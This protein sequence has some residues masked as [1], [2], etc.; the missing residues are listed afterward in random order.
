MEI[1]AIFRIGPPDRIL[2]IQCKLLP[3]HRKYNTHL[4]SKFR[5]DLWPE[6]NVRTFEVI[7]NDYLF[8]QKLSKLTESE[9]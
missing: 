6:K 5:F 1:D 8:C 7:K 4:K 3:F 2:I 9:N